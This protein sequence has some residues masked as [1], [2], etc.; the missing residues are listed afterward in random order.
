M[1]EV[2]YVLSCCSTAD[3]TK[4]FYEERNILFAKFHYEI[5]GKTY[6]DDL[7]QSLS[8]EEFYRLVK[9]GAMPVTSQVN[10]EEY[11]ELW[12]PSIKEGK[13]ILHLTL[14][15]GI[16]GTINSARI[17]ANELMEKYPDSKIIVVDSLAA[18][19]G[20]G[21]LM[22]YLA[23]LRDG[24]MS[25]EEISQWAE[26]HKLNINHWFFVSDLTHLKRGGRVSAVSAAFG[27]ALNICPLMNVD[28]MGRLIPRYKIRTKKKVIRETV[29]KMV[30]LAEGG[31]AYDGKCEISNSGTIEDAYALRDAIEETFPVLKGKI[32]INSIGAVIGSHTGVGTTALFFYGDKRVD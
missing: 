16:S 8:F 1:E 31:L 4:E 2:N 18:S 26:D 3:E 6:D 23:D 14:S 27:N 29:Q 28:Y 21:M 19:S 25:F 20:F 9:E 7:G 30:E 10:S 17:A 22:D 5:N 15:S 12:E 32:K 13:N 11:I 24:G